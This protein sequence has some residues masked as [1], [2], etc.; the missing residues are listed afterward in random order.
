VRQVV[1]L[2]AG[3]DTRAFRLAWPV[4]TRL[5]EID[6]P[7]VLVEK[8]RVIRADG[9]RPACERRVIGADL[10]Q[11]WGQL[12]VDSGFRRGQPSCWLAE[13]F[14]FYVPNDTITGILDQVD[15]LAAP[16]SWV[17]FD[18]PNG[19]TLVHAWTKPWIDMQARLGAPFLGTM[20]DPRA[21]MDARGWTATPVQAGDK[22]ANFGRWPY[23]PPPLDV[24]DMPRNWFVTAQKEE[25]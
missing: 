13:G 21:V 22:D 12:L 17:G 15:G 24:P 2:A 23:P 5:F 7:E 19:A 14:L 25:R 8:E 20:D 1:L 4:G 18:I 10:T 16:G 3:L 11:P 6:R 9:A